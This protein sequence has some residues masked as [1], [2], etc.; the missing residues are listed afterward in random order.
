VLRMD[1]DPDRH[2]DR[3]IALA[4][5]ATQLLER[6]QLVMWASALRSGVTVPLLTG[7]PCSD[8]ARGHRPPTDAQPQTPF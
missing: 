8:Q 1:H 7:S 5:A 6:G 3:A 2:D 4:L